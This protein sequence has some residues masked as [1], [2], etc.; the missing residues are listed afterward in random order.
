MGKSEG[1]PDGWIESLE[2]CYYFE[3][4]QE[5]KW[6]DAQVV[7]E[8]IGGHLAEPKTM[9]EVIILKSLAMLE[10]SNLDIESWWI[11]LTDIGHEGRWIWS[12]SI[13][14]ITVQDWTN[15]YKAPNT[16]DNQ[17]DCGAML[18]KHGFQWSDMN[19]E[20]RAYPLCQHKQGFDGYV[21]LRGGMRNAT[22]VSGN[23]F[24][25]NNAGYFG[26]VCDDYWAN[27]DADVVCRQLGFRSGTSVSQSFFGV[28]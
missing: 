26:P 17:N 14:D 23:V 15:V 11:G 22:T 16:T 20:E 21:E 19:C 18:F 4:S 3:S 2:G 12:T 10:H 24:A 9:D 13:E 25:T 5:L 28:V 8:S 1:C 7:C 27:V 6:M